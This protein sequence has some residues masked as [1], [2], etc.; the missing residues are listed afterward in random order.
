MKFV[1]ESIPENYLLY[2]LLLSIIV[3][4]VFGIAMVSTTG[5]HLLAPLDDTYIHL[6]CARRLAQGHFFSYTEGSGF[7]SGATSILYPVILAPIFWVGLG[8]VKALLVTF[9]FGVLCLFLSAIL[10]YLIGRDLASARVG[11]LASFLFLLNG[12]LVW[13]Y[14]SGMETGLFATLLLGGFYTFERWWSGGRSGDLIR[15]CILLSLASLTRPE[16]FIILLVFLI[17]ICGRAWRAYGSR[18][19]SALFALAPFIIYLS[20]V[21]IESGTFA[22]GGVLAKSVLAAPYYTFWEK[23]AKLV[24]NF[25]WIFGA[26]YGNLSNCFFYDGAMVR[27]FASGALYPF[28]IFPPGALLLTLAGVTMGGAREWRTG[29]AGAVILIS[30]ILFFGLASIT[31]SEAVSA[32]YFRYLAPFQ[33]MFLI[34]I[35]IGLYEIARVFRERGARVFRIAGIILVLL[36]APSVF[37]W[38]YIYGE[39]CSDLFEQHR[40]TSWWI[41]DATPKNAVIGVTDAG[42][43]GYFSHRR[44]YDIVG[45]VTPNQARHWRQ[46]I[47]S[48]FERFE[49]L[50]KKDLPD[51]VV[52]FPFVWGK[53]NFL[54]KPVHSAPLLKNITTMSRDFVVYKQDWS[55]LHSGNK[56]MAP[57]S[58]LKLIDALDV[59]DIQDE[60]AHNYEQTVAAERPSGWTFPNPRNFFHKAPA[61]GNIIADGGRALYASETFIV[62]LK[63]GKP[64]RLIARTETQAKS[65]AT[66]YVNGKMVGELVA[67][68]NKRG[69]WQ[70]PSILIPASDITKDSIRLRIVFNRAESW[71]LLFRS[72]HY[73]LYQEGE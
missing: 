21:R 1:R 42:I 23:V 18:S 51:Y 44:I 6:Q 61:D 48:A 39:N 69:K 68:P 50:P 7:S 25:A 16:G 20:L 14:L 29:N 72:Y 54:G 32:H 3:S 52:T 31:N 38:A 56:P 33:P 67:E 65:T 17:F 73:W 57:P 66:V 30:L 11:L 9:A 46:G 8:G 35:A 2:F 5:G 12:N 45:L 22:T 49:H 24:D 53:D 47:G 58:A 27:G 34:L 13:N 71:T 26:Y 4:A 55:M 59:A 41:K 40:R 60:Q 64:A 10:I 43:I 15:A 62:H 63:S 37:Y 19:L 36:I 70:E 28:L